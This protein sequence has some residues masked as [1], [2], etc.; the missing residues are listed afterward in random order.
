MEIDLDEKPELM[1]Q[2]TI[3]VMLCFA[4]YS[5]ANAVTRFYRKMLDE[6]GLTYPQYLIMVV[7]W[8][9]K[10]TTMKA[11][12]DRLDLDSSTLTPIV[13]KLESRGLV[14]RA[15]NRDDERILDIAPTAAGM[16]MRKAGCEAALAMTAHSGETL[17]TQAELRAR[18]MRVRDRL[19]SA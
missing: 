16:A 10:G 14:T 2:L 12:G 5:A 17:Q 19:I 13:K 3:D 6:L 1:D 7:L 4:M 9:T 11:L 15:R 18:L 8:E